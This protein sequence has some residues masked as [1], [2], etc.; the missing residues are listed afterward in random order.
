MDH[1]TASELSGMREVQVDSLQ[2]MCVIQRHSYTS[3]NYDQQIDSWADDAA[4]TACGLDMRPG[5]ERWSNRATVLVYDATVRLAITVNVD[6]K[7]RIKVTQRYGSTLAVP[8]VFEIVGPMQEG[9]SGKRLMLN[10]IES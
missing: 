5:S 2:D 7:D 4:A 8:L 1:F 9:V 3:D 6:E 10:R